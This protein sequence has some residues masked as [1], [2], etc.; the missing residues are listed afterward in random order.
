MFHFFNRFTKMQSL[1]GNDLQNA[2]EVEVEVIL[3]YQLSSKHELLTHNF[4]LKTFPSASLIHIFSNLQRF[5]PSAAVQI[6]QVNDA[7]W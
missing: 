6:W 4:L 2:D 5:F 3:I 7:L 1:S